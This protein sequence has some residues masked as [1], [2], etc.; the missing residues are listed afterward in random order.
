MPLR[1][2]ERRIGEQPP[3]LGRVVVCHGSL[4]VLARGQRL[5]QLP[6]EPAEEADPSLVHRTFLHGL[7][8]C[9]HRLDGWTASR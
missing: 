7:G 8:L 9:C 2:G 4:E 6:A 5:A 3:R 1:L